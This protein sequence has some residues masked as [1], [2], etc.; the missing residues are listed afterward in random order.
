M[1][2]FDRRAVLVTTGL[3]ALGLIT[4]CKRGTSSKVRVGIAAGDE[5]TA[6]KQILNKAAPQDF[7][8]TELPYQSLRERLSTSLNQ[9][10]DEFDLVM[11]DDPWFPELSPKLVGVDDVVTSMRGDFIPASLKL[12]M[13]PY[14]KGELRAVPYVGNCQLLFHRNDLLTAGGAN[15]VPQSW[16]TLRQTAKAVRS[17][18]GKAG[19]CVRAKTGA[20]LVSDF[21][22]LLWSYGG[23]LFEDLG[24]PTAANVSVGSAPTVAALEAYKD[25]VS[26]SPAG[27]LN[28]DWAEM[29]AAFSRGDAALELNWPA[30]IKNLDNEIPKNAA[31]GRVWGVSLPPTESNAT[32]MAGNWLLGIPRKSSNGDGARNALRLLL[33]NQREAVLLGNPPTRTS[34]FSELGGRPELFYLPVLG[35]A[36]AKST[37]RPRTRKWSQV[38]DAVSV[39]VSRFLTENGSAIASANRLRAEIARIMQP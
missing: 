36:L 37:P 5:G 13:E 29:T 33:Q 32:S 22:P 39:E 9:D 4:G 12:G 3:A 25:L 38:E 10:L 6:I 21:L 16:T 15:G 26:L 23:D 19:Y 14:G 34:L 35:Q 8:I 24:N 30:A 27:A 28:F 31:R 1:D 20:P 7:A 11:I 2:S 18:T 17:R